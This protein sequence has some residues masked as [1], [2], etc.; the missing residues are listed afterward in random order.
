MALPEH[1]PEL[2]LL[3]EALTILFCEVDD[4]YTHLN[5]RGW[6]YAT[7]KQ[8]SDSE[9]LTLAL[10]KQLRGME[11]ERAF[12]RDVA[13][14]F[15]H[16]FPGMVDLHPSSFHRRVRKLR[17]YLEPLRRAI[18]PVLGGRSRD[19]D[20]RLDL[21]FGFA[22]QASF[23]RLGLRWGCLGEVGHFQR[24]R[25]EVAPALRHTNRVSRSATS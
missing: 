13:R 17:R 18:L 1:T 21:A 4:A 7:L 15:S 11:S 25:G 16:L 24:L 12:L 5:P 14:F 2:A 19:H 22:P 20:R 8:L 23:S 10:F 3:E 6:L 9:I